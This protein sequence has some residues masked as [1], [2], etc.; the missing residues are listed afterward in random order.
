MI[1]MKQTPSQNE[2]H[3]TV[4]IVKHEFVSPPIDN[5]VA[6]KDIATQ[7]KLKKLLT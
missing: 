5:I 6:R 4:V 1:F 7:E 2:L 3:K